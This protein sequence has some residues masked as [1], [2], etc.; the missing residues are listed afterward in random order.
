M[1]TETRQFDGNVRAH[2]AETKGK[3]F[4]GNPDG[5]PFDKQAWLTEGGKNSEVE[6]V[7]KVIDRADDDSR[8]MGRIAAKMTAEDL[9]I[10]NDMDQDRYE[11]LVKARTGKQ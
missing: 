1:T 11:D 7:K 4:F 5:T 10:V 3:I 2:R 8:N 6:E 9:A